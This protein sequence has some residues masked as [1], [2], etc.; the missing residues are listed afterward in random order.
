MKRLWNYKTELNVAVMKREV[1][2]VYMDK[3]GNEEGR[4]LLKTFPYIPGSSDNS[5]LIDFINKDKTRREREESYIPP[6]YFHKKLP[7][8]RGMGDEYVIYEDLGEGKNPREV[9]ETDSY[10]DVILILSAINKEWESKQLQK[11]E[12]EGK[13]PFENKLMYIRETQNMFDVI[14]TF[15]SHEEGAKDLLKRYMD[16][17]SGRPVSI[18]MYRELWTDMNRFINTH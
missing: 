18:T 10:M 7:R 4:Q 11:Q 9:A 3:E 16:I 13:V 12:E 1:Y 8:R 5:D 6:R 14:R 17:E 15:H 2:I